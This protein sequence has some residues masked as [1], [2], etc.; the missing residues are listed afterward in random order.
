MTIKS[1]D[2]NNSPESLKKYSDNWDNT[3]KKRKKNEKRQ[4]NPRNKKSRGEEQD[5]DPSRDQ[6]PEK[7]AS[8]PHLR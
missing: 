6:D 2:S 8:M 3:F 5:L 1:T 7:L 4:A